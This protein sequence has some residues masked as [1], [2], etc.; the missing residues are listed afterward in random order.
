[1]RNHLVGL[2]SLLLV[3]CSAPE[4][5]DDSAPADAG[6][7]EDGG[8]DTP[9]RVEEGR[10]VDGHG[11]PV[12][13][14][15][16]GFNNWVW[17]D[18]SLAAT[19]HD[20]RDLQRVADMGMNAIRFYMTYRMFEDDAAPYVY[21]ES[22]F[23]WLDQN[24][25]WARAHGI[26]LIPNLHV[27]PGGWQSECE[28][29]DLWEVPENQDRVVALWRAIAERYASEPVIAGYDLLNE[30]VPTQSAAQWQTLAARTV[31][32]IREVDD[33]HMIVVEHVN[34]VGASAVDCDWEL[35]IEDSFFL[36][37]DP[38]VLYEL[39]AYEPYAFTY[40]LLW[41]QG[42]GGRYPDEA[43]LDWFPY[44]RE[45]LP[46][47]RASLERDLRAVVD[48]GARNGVPLYLGEFGA[49]QPTF[50]DDKGGLRWVEDMLEVAIADGLHFTYHDYHEDGFGIYPGQGALPDPSRANQELID[51]FTTKLRE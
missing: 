23:A 16:V 27:P 36:L 11:Q 42:D 4:D 19:H 1:M 46:R 7:G 43:Q 3:S 9:L 31:Q 6:P 12:F 18:P 37:D 13:L 48:W 49:G 45:H 22:G 34:A 2:A 38:N 8:D 5:A 51:L 44:A 35:T 10:V 30:P 40:Q 26:Y 14:R 47:S 32:A 28:G 41:G 39:H 20:E 17:D 25:E 29:G 33:R 15:G 21:Q 24:V 50:A